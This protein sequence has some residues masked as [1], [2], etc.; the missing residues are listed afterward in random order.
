[1]YSR[2]H[3][4]PLNEAE[5]VLIPFFE[6]RLARFDELRVTSEATDD[7]FEFDSWRWR[8]Y[9]W[10]RQQKGQV[11][12]RIETDLDVPLERYDRL[13]LQGTFAS[14]I[15]VRVE[16]TIDGT[17]QTPIDAVIERVGEDELEGPVRGAHL[18]AVRITFIA[19]EDS[20][21][22]KGVWPIALGFACG[23]DRERLLARRHP[24]DWYGMLRP[25][26]EPVEVRPQLGVW[27]DADELARIREKAR[28]PLYR[29]LMASLRRDAQTHM[30][31]IDPER[32]GLD[33]LAFGRSPENPRALEVDSA[34]RTC[35]FV[36]IVDENPDMLRFAAR[37]GLAL[38][39]HPGAWSD[40]YSAF[41][42]MIDCHGP[43]GV[44]ALT[45]AV[46][47]M[48][49]WAGC[50]LTE[51]GWRQCW[52]ALF[53]KGL[54][55]LLRNFVFNERMYRNNTGVYAAGALCLAGLALAK[56]SRQGAPFLTLVEDYFARML[57]SE[58]RE[59][60]GT[61]EGPGYWS[62]D[63]ARL[64]H[65][66]LLAK[67][68]GLPVKEYMRERGIP[69]SLLATGDYF[70]SFL[71]NDP[72]VPP[73]TYLPV[74]DSGWQMPYPTPTPE[75]IAAV[76]RL[77]GSKAFRDLHTLGLRRGGQSF[78]RFHVGPQV[79]FEVEPTEDPVMPRPPGFQLLP[80]V[81]LLTSRRP[82]P[83]GDVRL[84]LLGCAAD[85]QGHEHDHKGSLILEVAGEELLIDPGAGSYSDPKLH[86]LQRARS[87]NLLVPYGK[88]GEP[89][90]QRHHCPE[91]IV[92]QARGDET[93]LYSRIDVTPAWEG[94]ATRCVREIASDT[95]TKIRLTD[96][97]VLPEPGVVAVHFQSRAPIEEA[98][99][100]WRVR[101]ERATL[102]IRP[103]WPDVRGE[104]DTDSTDH[105]NRKVYRLRLFAEDR[106]EYTLETVLTVLPR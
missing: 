62:N 91:A 25:A 96:S 106:A 87:H 75:C 72:H 38:V 97:C 51:D 77:T 6:A 28:T 79:L 80:A 57:S 45:A 83:V 65:L 21:E 105:I 81:G 15:R 53:H 84:L 26:G 92:P 30:E 89:C 4:E 29:P 88:D 93:A 49:D 63:A 36:G 86:V 68:R 11:V 78:G 1:M 102:E 34:P 74:N 43:L 56:A 50:M 61:T 13:F 101:G 71:V 27:F 54:S 66:L 17:A 82:S 33:L 40:R 99:G 46:V 47:E 14:G 42:G 3:I 8:Q 37:C 22:K 18:D 103:Q 23:R 19:T 94:V 69:E 41:P 44:M 48:M 76:A 58:F 31:R 16:V 98:P 9:A 64:N 70:L 60:G 52:H 12:L 73:G 39:N 67:H 59:D 100:A 104:L 24:A 2:K 85:E 90:V 32:R 10:P 7:P 5:G 20:A 35:A 95:P 55:E